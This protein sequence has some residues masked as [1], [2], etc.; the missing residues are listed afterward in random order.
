L[1]LTPAFTATDTDYVWYCT[2]GLSK[3]ML[4]LASQGTISS[5]SQTGSQLLIPLSVVPNQAVVLVAPNG[6]QYW[7]RCLPPTFPH[8]TVSQSGTATPG[9][10]VTGT[11]SNSKMDAPGYPMI[12]NSYGTPVWY[13]NNIGGSA[14]NVE[15]LPGDEDVAWAHSDDP[16]N[17]YNLETQTASELA[18][19][20][21]PPDGH[22]LFFDTSGNYWMISTPIESGYDLSSLGI[23]NVHDVIGCVVQEMNPQGTLI[24]QWSANNYVSPLEADKLAGVS[25][26]LGVPAFDAYHCNSIDVDPLD[27]DHI[28]V[29]MRHVGVFLID[30]ATGDIIWKLGGTSVAP[31]NGEPVL[32][33]TGDP[34]GAIEGQHDARFQSDNAITMFDDHTGLSGAA[35][36][37]EYSIDTSNET[38]NL[39]WEYAEPTGQSSASMGSVRIYDQN[40]MPYDEAGSAYGG[41]QETVIDWGHGA[42][43]AGFTVLDNSNNVLL[44]VVFPSGIDGNRTQKVPFSV[45]NLTELRN[46]AGT[47]FP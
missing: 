4:T 27:P 29:S 39:V 37:V 9:Y 24:W 1:V 30:K 23:D 46:S 8:L 33:I 6:T 19:P 11:F 28:L 10:Y 17:V 34:E 26:R 42:P 20:I 44:N 22:E 16:Y 3:L 32:T 14:Q 38:A 18:P 21:S 25:T 47:S 5:G 40:T 36:G 7:I 41:A 12:L 2:K 45:L 13:L 35:R 43:R 31:M 15:I